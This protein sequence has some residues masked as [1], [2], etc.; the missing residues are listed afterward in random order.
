MWPFGSA[1]ENDVSVL[2]PPPIRPSP[3]DPIP[4]VPSMPWPPN[5]ENTIADPSAPR[6]PQSFWAR[7]RPFLPN[8]GSKAEDSLEISSTPIPDSISSNST[9]TTMTSAESTTSS[10]SPQFT[11]YVIRVEDPD[12]KNSTTTVDQE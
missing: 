2:N 6:L 3:I 10:S 12:M 8:R 1:S 11:P 4:F 9:S 7:N 5:Q